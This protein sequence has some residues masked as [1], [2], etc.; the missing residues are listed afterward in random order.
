MLKKETDAQHAA[1]SRKNDLLKIPVTLTLSPVYFSTQSCG[2]LL[3][4]WKISKCNLYFF[5]LKVDL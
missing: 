4:D 2:Y 1:K 3:Q 5:P